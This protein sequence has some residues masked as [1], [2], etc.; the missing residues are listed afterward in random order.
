MVDNSTIA[1]DARNVVKLGCVP[2]LFA[3]TFTINTLKDR[4][5]IYHSTCFCFDNVARVE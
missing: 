1:A 2:V 5:I 3:L 4:H